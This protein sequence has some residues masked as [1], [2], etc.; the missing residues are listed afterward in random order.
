MTEPSLSE[1]IRRV[2]VVLAVGLLVHIALRMFHAAYD[3]Y[4]IGTVNDT[5]NAQL[6]VV[7]VYAPVAALSSRARAGLEASSAPAPSKLLPSLFLSLWDLLIG[8]YF[9]LLSVN[10][11]AVVH[12]TSY[13]YML[14]PYLLVTALLATPVLLN[15]QKKTKAKEEG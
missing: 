1:I 10:A 13:W 9:V 7:A 8:F 14:V 11:F 5:L 4:P 2:L 3:P 15:Q 12:G 6:A